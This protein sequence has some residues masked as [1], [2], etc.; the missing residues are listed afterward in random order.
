[1]VTDPLRAAALRHRAAKRPP[2]TGPP[3]LEPEKP[4]P[5]VTQGPRSM[6]PAPRRTETIDELIR[7]AVWELR[8]RE[9]WTRLA[10]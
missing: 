3:S 5:I 10:P 4:L 9:R 6:P 2:A 8:G 7:S 1:M